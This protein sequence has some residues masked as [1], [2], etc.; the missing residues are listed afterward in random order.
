MITTILPILEILLMKS[1]M[2][3]GETPNYRSAIFTLLY[4]QQALDLG[5]HIA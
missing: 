1:I 3:S 2:I 4:Q 5:N